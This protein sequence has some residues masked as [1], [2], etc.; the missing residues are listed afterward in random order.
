MMQSDES[1][2]LVERTVQQVE[3]DL[4]FT[5]DESADNNNYNNSSDDYNRH[6]EE[7]H[8]ELQSN[9]VAR[10]EPKGGPVEQWESDL[11]SER[12]QVGGAAA[13]GA[14]AGMKHHYERIK[15]V[16]ILGDS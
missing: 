11:K 3:N 10:P 2:P 5:I 14:I 4:N 12:R 9:D 6:V 15:I 16:V 7:V 13:A 1:E 8:Y